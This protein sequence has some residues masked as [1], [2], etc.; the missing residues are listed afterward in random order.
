MELRIKCIINGEDNIVLIKNDNSIE[1][2]IDLIKNN[3]NITSKI[4]MFYQDNRVLK[5]Y[6]TLTL[7]QFLFQ[8]NSPVFVLNS[9]NNNEDNSNNSNINSNIQIKN[10]NSNVINYSNNSKYIQIN[11]PNYSIN[12][13]NYSNSNNNPYNTSNSSNRIQISIENFTSRNEVFNCIDTYLEN[14]DKEHPYIADNKEK[15][16]LFTFKDSDLAFKVFTYLNTTRMDNQMKVNINF[17]KS[18]DDKFNKFNCSYN[19]SSKQQEENGS[20]SNYNNSNHSYSYNDVRSKK[21]IGNSN[22]SNKFNSNRSLNN[23]YSNNNGHHT[24][25]NKSLFQPNNQ[26][27][28]NNYK[29]INSKST[30]G[31]PIIIKSDCTKNSTSIISDKVKF[32]FTSDLV[33]KQ[34]DFKPYAVKEEEFIHRQIKLDKIKPVSYIFI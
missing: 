21:I 23:N 32:D 30:N 25:N 19:T 2:L 31:M 13:T 12:N 11:N 33:R 22:S 29:M 26:Y 8:D 7:K 28:S 3:K 5:N 9:H 16:I 17:I 4:T 10:N 18:Y 24:K 1:D 14:L 15:R 27:S 20:S 6:Y 34:P